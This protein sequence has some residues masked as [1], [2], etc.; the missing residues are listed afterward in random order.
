MRGP[1]NRAGIGTTQ[2]AISLSGADLESE[3]PDWKIMDLD[4]VIMSLWKLAGSNCL[5]H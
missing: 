5:I 1:L 2:R 3:E 4:Y